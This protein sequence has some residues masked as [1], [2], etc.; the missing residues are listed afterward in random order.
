[1]WAVPN[2]F[3]LN[4][5]RDVFGANSSLGQRVLGGLALLPV[6]GWAGRGIG[7]AADVARGLSAAGD[8]A[9]TAAA[10][11]EA[12]SGGSGDLINL[13]DGTNTAGAEAI[14]TEGIDLSVGRLNLAFNPAGQGGFYVT[15]DLRQAAQRAR[16][17]AGEF[18]GEPVIL[19]YAMS[20]GDLAQLNGLAFATADSKWVRFMTEGRQ[21]TLSHLF[22]YVEGPVLRNPGE[23]IQGLPALPLRGGGGHQLAI[24]TQE[25][26]DLFNSSL[27]P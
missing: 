8:V 15:N 21:G 13:Y 22:D 1:M 12:V 23:V 19:R 6:V 24:F 9:E 25:A 5:L 27:A 18:G 10:G 20:C 7:L 16:F 26:V 4:P 17:I 2:V 14:S 3:V 11:A